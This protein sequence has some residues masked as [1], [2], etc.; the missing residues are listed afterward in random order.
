VNV[1]AYIQ[2]GRMVASAYLKMSKSGA[3]FWNDTRD[4]GGVYCRLEEWMQDGRECLD[5]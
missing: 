1:D 5:G 4:C 3:A 2:S